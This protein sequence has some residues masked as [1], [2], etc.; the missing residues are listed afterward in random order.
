MSFLTAVLQ[1]LLGTLVLVGWALGQS[2][3]ASPPER[4]FIQVENP[5]DYQ[6]YGGSTY[7]LNPIFSRRVPRFDRMGNFLMVGDLAYSV[8]EARPGL[9]RFGGVARGLYHQ[10]VILN[11]SVLRDSYRGAR[12]SLML[13]TANPD[14]DSRQLPE[15][16][17]TRFSPLTM[18]ITRF[19]G[20]RFDTRGQRNQST[21]IYSRGAADRKRFSFFSPGRNERSPVI[22]WGGHWESTVGA[23]LRL[24]TTFVNQHITDATARKGSIFRGNIPYQMQS[25]KAIYVRLTSDDPDHGQV[26][27]AVQAVSIVLTGTDAGGQTR[28]LTDNPALATG[29]VELEPALTPVPTGRKA[30]D[31]YEASGAEQVE[32]A[33][34]LPAG[35]QPSQAEFTALVSGDYQLGVRQVHDFTNQSGV[36]SRNG[37]PA[38]ADP[39]HFERAFL[40]KYDPRYPTDFKFPEKDPTYTV[41]RAGGRGSSQFHP[42]HF[43]YGIPTAQTLAGTNFSFKYQGFSADGEVAY[44]AQDFK[45][46]VSTGGRDQKNYLAYYLKGSGA[47][48]RLP[49]RLKSQLAGEV[50]SIPAAYSGGYD[51]RRGGSIFST[52]VAPSPTGAMTQE[53][54]LVD[55]NDDGDQWPDEHP[56][57]SAVSDINDA[58]VFPGLDEDGDNVIDTDRNANGRPDWVEPFLSYYADP[59]EFV[60]D[61]DFNNN[62]LPDMTENDDEADYPYRRGQRGYHGFVNLPGLL[63]QAERLIFGHYHT[64]ATADGGESSGRYLRLEGRYRHQRLG[65]VAAKGVVKWV[66]DDLADPSYIWQ[67]SED[68]TVNMLVVQ[69]TER[70]TA[71][72]LLALIPPP[73]DPLLMRKS[74]VNTL[75]VE[76]NLTPLAGMEVRGRNKFSLNRQH[77]GQFAD[78]TSQ[79]DHT[80]Y[81]WTLSN[82]ISYTWEVRE[83]L[84]TS[85]KVKHLFRW[86]GGYSGT[87]VRFSV[88]AP[89]A[90][91]TLKVTAKVRLHFG[92]EGAPLLP[93]RYADLEDSSRNYHQRTT[94]L[95]ARSDWSYWGWL[96]AAEL[97]MQWQSRKVEGLQDQG[98]RT[99]F[100]ESYVGF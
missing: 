18:N 41:A 39:Q 5:I 82:R 9:S 29:G 69:S 95:L 84:S 48:P 15:G 13:L 7:G 6:S 45:F 37:W 75:Y 90:E 23:A 98:Q 79:D 87:P 36:T 44:N 20:L 42:V 52:E 100:F 72:N 81:R 31:H 97:G 26:V 57:D 51:A 56:N 43:D 64:E 70:T 92:Q 12:Y 19:A 99:F 40:T 10:Q 16:V 77:A 50:F 67:V 32:F 28:R 63:P 1:G 96:M 3:D 38:T 58:G 46:P 94:L 62:D 24:G 34:N 91:A 71:G 85:V 25:P 80:L 60:Y 88:I 17:R 78:G 89:I 66:E 74:T 86:D 4:D 65:E 22:L 14:L 8:D 21:F 61:Q 49:A 27:A 93:F 55:D 35:F 2:L 30:G 83:N 54:N 68:P 53:F 59:P 76:N 33:F 11:Y 47:L 73:P